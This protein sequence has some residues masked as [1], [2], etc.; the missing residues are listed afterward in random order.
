[1]NFD[2]LLQNSNFVLNTIRDWY[3]IY[4]IVKKRKVVDI[5][6]NRS[7][8]ENRHYLLPNLTI[9]EQRKDNI[10]KYGLIVLNYLKTNKQ[11]LYQ[12]LL[13][14]DKLTDYR[15]NIDKDFQN[16]VN[17]LIKR[18]AEKKINEDLKEKRPTSMVGLM[19]NLKNT[20]EKIVLYEY[21]S[22]Y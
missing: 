22:N 20:A 9:R 21:F 19:D 14:Q 3:F 11:A 5:F 4:H 16:K 13:T 10:G 6:N 7:I 1:M 8:R 2:F 15:I 17:N 18:L 12:S